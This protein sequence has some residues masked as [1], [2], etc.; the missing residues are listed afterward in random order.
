MVSGV[1][2]GVF[3][4]DSCRAEAAAQG[5]AGWVRNLPDGT[6]EAVFEG[7]PEAV[8]R[9]VAW[10]RVGPPAASVNGVAVRDEEPGGRGGF[11]VRPTP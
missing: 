10:A 2:Q 5:V 6:V 9:M 11:E 1:V 4:R 3:F 8:E 7:T